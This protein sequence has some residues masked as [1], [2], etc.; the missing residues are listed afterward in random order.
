MGSFKV[1]LVAYFLLLSL[2]PL[3]AAFW[4]FSTVAA[5]SETRRV[6]AR[7]QAGLRATLAA[8]QE[9]LGSADAAAGQ[10][11]HEP[12]FQRAL[13]ARNRAALERMLPGKSHLSVEAPGGFHIGRRDPMAVTR[14]VE[15]VGANG[16]HGSVVAS[17][18]LDDALV[19]SLE[20]RSGLEN[21]D[22]VVLIQNG[23][24]VAG[25]PG[26][27]GRVDVHSGK[28]QTI[29]LDNTSYRSLVA[30]TIGG[31]PNATLGVISPQA[32][33]DATNR[34]ARNRLLV[35]LLAAL[36][37]VA[38]V[39]YVEGRAIVRTIRR[40][41]DAARAIARGDLK[42]RVPV[43]GRDE[44]ALLGRTFNQMAFQLQTRLDELQAE[45]GRLRD[46]ISRFGEALGATHD[47]DQLMRLIVETAIEATGASGGVFVGA[48]GELVR[49]GYPDKGDDKI[50]VPLRAGTMDFGSLLLFGDDFP[51]EDRMTR[52]SLASH[53]V[54]ALTASA[55]PDREQRALAG[56]PPASPTGASARNRCGRLARVE[57]FGGSLAVV[58]ADLDWFKDVNDRYGHPAGDTVLHDF[59]TL[60]QE[61]LRDVD[62]AGRWGG[63]EFLMVLPGTD[64]A[65]GARVAER[66]RV[67]LAGRIVLTADGT[68]IPVTASFGVA[69]TPPHRTASE[70]FA[71]ADAAMYEAK[72]AGK[73]RV[74]TAPDPVRQA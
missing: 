29:S 12:A 70:L 69:A 72:R 10:L 6:D 57:R 73:N 21:Y 66:I 24:I 40:L 36:L 26:V 62:I 49:V 31:R 30:G 15:V 43:Q 34:A 32:R 38:C 41:V 33:I 7:L 1:K 42:Q 19:K 17:V 37:F 3:A 61:T 68:P 48:N 11:A 50:E 67:A 16:T 20:T 71:S 4:G 13:L 2:L 45:R 65:G 25:P 18:P 54:V 35:G 64:L 53:A 9:A 74:E 27:S 59:A 47:S 14:Q 39:A 58:V 8:Y 63:E 51:R 56:P 22:H 28:T 55:A 5:R 44:F 52:L 46:V 23:R 60:L